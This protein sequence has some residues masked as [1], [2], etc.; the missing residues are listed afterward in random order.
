MVKST[1]YTSIRVRVCVC[2]CVRTHTCAWTL[3]QIC[4]CLQAELVGLISD[5]VTSISLYETGMI[6]V[7]LEEFLN[8]LNGSYMPH[9]NQ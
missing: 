6:F 8:A 3:I 7:H 2:V 4:Y 1:A 9:V 5:P